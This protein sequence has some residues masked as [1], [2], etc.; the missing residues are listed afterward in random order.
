VYSYWLLL[1]EASVDI[2]T[3]APLLLDS[4][5]L[6]VPIR[7]QLLTS[8]AASTVFMLWAWSAF[9]AIGF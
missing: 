1:E 4:T 5:Q 3:V 9:L 6:A 8:F 7:Q 2:R